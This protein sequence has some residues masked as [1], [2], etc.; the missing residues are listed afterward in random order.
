M[1]TNALDRAANAQPRPRELV[2]FGQVDFDIWDAVLEKGYGKVPFDPAQHSEDRLVTAIQMSVV[3]LAGSPLRNNIDREMIAESNE[4][5]KIVMP[6][7][8]AIGGNLQTLKH[9]F[10]QV[11]LVPTGRRYTNKAG[12]EK[13]QTTFSFEALFA[14]EA[15]CRAAADA[16]FTPP[17]RSER[18]APAP[19]PAVASGNRAL[20]LKFVARLWQQAGQD[21]EV[22]QRLF[23]ANPLTAQLRVED[24]DVL[25][26][27]A[28]I[29]G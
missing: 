19:A 21:V 15:A 2:V 7:I 20:A 5:A 9:A 6:S 29:E 10:V 26:L 13:E 4:W 18:V 28:P 1:T 8:R 12:E 25:A 17:P 27:L 23:A 11:R 22:L 14:D 3:P 24:E 16:F